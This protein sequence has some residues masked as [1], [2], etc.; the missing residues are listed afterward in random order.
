MNIAIVSDVKY[1]AVFIPKVDP[2]LTEAMESGYGRIL[3]EELA[4]VNATVAAAEFTD[5]YHM[6]SV[7]APADIS[8]AVVAHTI[9]DNACKALIQEFE[10][11]AAWGSIYYDRVFIKA[12]SKP[13]AKKIEEFL[14]I[15]IEGL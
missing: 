7:S 3:R 6:I 15:S 12:G 4:Q 8:P 5:R 10:A 14:E 11:L 1:H 13:S 2:P 9:K